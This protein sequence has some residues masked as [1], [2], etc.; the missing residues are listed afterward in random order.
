MR[1]FWPTCV[2]AYCLWFAQDPQILKWLPKLQRSSPKRSC[3]ASC[4]IESRK[5][6]HTMT[7]TG[8][9]LEETTQTQDDSQADLEGDSPLCKSQKIGINNAKPIKK[10]TTPP[11]W[12]KSP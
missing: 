1:V 3:W 7:I 12:C 5:T 2:M 6:T 11:L 9:S 10:K 8:T 4:S